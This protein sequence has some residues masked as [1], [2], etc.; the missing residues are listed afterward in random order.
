MPDDWELSHRLD[1]NDPS[2]GPALARNGYTHV[3]NY[4]NEL[5]GD[6]S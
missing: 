5:A 3:E 1:P 6:F 2:D 4:L